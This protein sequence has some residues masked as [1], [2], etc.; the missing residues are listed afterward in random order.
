MLNGRELESSAATP[1]SADPAEIKKTAA[2]VILTTFGNW[3]LHTFVPL[4]RGDS[5]MTMARPQASDRVVSS[6]SPA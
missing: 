2:A 3:M 5:E 4:P 1:E 6:N